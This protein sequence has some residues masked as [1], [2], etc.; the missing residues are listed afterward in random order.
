[1]GN[2]RTAGLL[3]SLLFAWA[4]TGP[5]WCCFAGECPACHGTGRCPACGGLGYISAGMIHGQRGA[6]GC[7]T[8]GGFPG[9][10]VSGPPG[11]PGDGKC[12][13][14][15]GTGQVPGS[16]SAEQR[17]PPPAGPSA[18]ELARQ[19]A[20]A[21]ANQLNQ[22]GVG[23]FNGRRWQQALAAFRAA[24]EKWPD[25]KTIQRNLRNAQ[26][27]LSGE[28]LHRAADSASAEIRRAIEDQ[29]I[30]E[31]AD[32]QRKLAE[33]SE[34]QAEACRKRFADQ[35]RDR[36]Q[37]LEARQAAL[38]RMGTGPAAEPAAPMAWETQITNPQIA[39]IMRD[40]RAIEVP[41]PLPTR[42]VAMSWRKLSEDYGAQ[43]LDQGGDAGFLLWDLFGKIGGEAPLHC[44]VVLI[45]GKVFIAGEDGAYVHLVKQD[46]VFDDALGYLKDAATTRQFAELV[47]DLKETG[48]APSSADENMVRA[49][50][51]IL[52]PSLGSS[53]M[54][55]AWDAML[56]PEATAAMVRK[57]CLEAGG[58]MV[59]E[60]TEGLLGDLTR[61]KGLYDAARLQRREAQTL[62]KHCGDT[63][64]QEQLKKVI[65]HADY[66]LQNTYRVER[67]GPILA[68]S[69]IE[70]VAERA[71]DDD[72]GL[73]SVSLL[74]E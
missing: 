28:Q 23:H 63:L 9:N 61:Q 56:S 8:C 30:G 5:A 50:R 51:A 1:M 24:L 53:G 18:E 70:K 55:I 47:R 20:H 69:A 11:R 36:A 65:L 64:E 13:V 31:L 17:P 46:K 21:E 12:R 42:H 38:Q 43:A 26:N 66:V 67:A 39:K 71:A 25:N 72:S 27:A 73:K 14:C 49:A 68:G 60:G 57:A 45:V 32:L 58:E 41:P 29:Q 37:F 33:R 52:D 16:P 44:K 40:L 15:H 54:R 74:G 19:Q 35:A 2:R 62:L 22:V 7:A 59:S 34:S 3:L 4:F 10:P 6:Y 48:Q